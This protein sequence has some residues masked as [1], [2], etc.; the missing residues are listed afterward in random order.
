MSNFK[1]DSSTPNA[2]QQ[3]FNDFSGPVG[4]DDVAYGYSKI[5]T[6]STG[7]T[8]ATG[9]IEF[10]YTGPNYPPDFKIIDVIP[11]PYTTGKNTIIDNSSIQVLLDGAYQVSWDMSIDENEVFAYLQVMAC[12]N[13]DITNNLASAVTIMTNSPFPL[14]LAGNG[15]VELKARDKVSLYLKPVMY[16]N[17]PMVPTSFTI[18]SLNFTVNKI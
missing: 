16:E 9:F 15:I 10:T 1:I 18:Y 17:V 5:Y 7:F 6:Y 3:E 11:P 14:N 8:G 12:V 13:N 2:L 4:I